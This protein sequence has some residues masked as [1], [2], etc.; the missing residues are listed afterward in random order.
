MSDTRTAALDT[1]YS[2]SVEQ[3]AVPPVQVTVNM[4]ASHES[5]SGTT[6]VFMLIATT[7]PRRYDYEGSTIEL[8]EDSDGVRWLLVQVDREVDQRARYAS[9]VYPSCRSLDPFSD[10]VLAQLWRKLV[11]P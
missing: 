1:L 2:V 11:T 6:G 7:A 4:S 5:K 10:G 8:L 9:G 3:A